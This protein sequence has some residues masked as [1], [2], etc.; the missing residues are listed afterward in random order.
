MIVQGDLDPSKYNYK[1]YKDENEED[2]YICLG[3][4]KK[5][6]EIITTNTTSTT[7]GTTGGQVSTTQIPD[8]S[9]KFTKNRC[10]WSNEAT[11]H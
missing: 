11:F 1:C 5:T 4:P 2:T 7:G 8:G 6:K 3:F 9:P 10:P